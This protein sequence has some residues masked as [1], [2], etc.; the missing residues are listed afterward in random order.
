MEAGQEMKTSHQ[1]Q[2]KIWELEHGSPYVLPSMDDTKP[3]G[4]VVKFWELLK[5]SLQKKDN[6]ALVSL[7]EFP[8]WVS[9]EIITNNPLDKGKSFK[10]DSTNILQYA[11]PLFYEEHFKLAIS[12]CDNPA[13]CLV[14]HGNFHKKPMTCDYLFCY[15]FKKEDGLIQERCFS[16]SKIGNSYKLN[17]HWIR[18]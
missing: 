12:L 9:N 2:Q 15:M 10:L 16:V 8:F 13:D 1:E 17:A 11:R 4:V 14:F 3:S 5:E 7:C 6:V 18:Q